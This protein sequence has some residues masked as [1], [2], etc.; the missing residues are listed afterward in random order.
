MIVGKKEASILEGVHNDL[1]GCE[2]SSAVKS[3]RRF[4]SGEIIGVE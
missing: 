4:D 2:R 1:K 3:R